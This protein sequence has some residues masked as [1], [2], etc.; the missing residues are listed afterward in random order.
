METSK[1]FW[2]LTGRKICGIWWFMGQEENE[3]IE[4][5][6]RFGQLGDNCFATRNRENQNLKCWGRRQET[7]AGWRCAFGL[8]L[9]HSE[10]TKSP[11]SAFPEG[12]DPSIPTVNNLMAVK[13][14]DEF[15]KT[16]F[17]NVKRR[18]CT[19]GSF[20]FRDISSSFFPLAQKHHPTPLPWAP[21]LRI[22]AGCSHCCSPFPGGAWRMFTG[23]IP[24][25]PLT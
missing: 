2:T 3:V 8:K 1:W 22:K 23:K 24:F 21:R 9:Q 14:T 15:S 7:G 20:Q 12:V 6:L 5:T 17:L 16:E 19:T 10:E 25:C 13:H 11:P 18:S 4:V